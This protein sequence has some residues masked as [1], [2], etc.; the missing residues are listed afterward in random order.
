MPCA[1]FCARRVVNTFSEADFAQVVQFNSQASSQ[2]GKLLS[3]NP[4]NRALLKGF[5]NGLAA[6]GSTDF[7]LAFETAFT[8]L[9]NSEVR[10]SLVI[11]PLQRHTLPCNALSCHDTH[12]P[13]WSPR[14]TARRPLAVT[15]PSSS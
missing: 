2:G 9:Q 13:L 15:R 5:I 3:M 6:G 11:P 1:V 12:P 4:I 7:A 8:I 10:T 14:P